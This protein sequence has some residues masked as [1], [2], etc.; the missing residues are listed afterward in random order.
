MSTDVPEPAALPSRGTATDDIVRRL[1]T[2]PS[3]IALRRRTGDG[4]ADVDVTE[5]ADQV[6]CV[7]KGLIASG[8]DQGARVALLASTRPA[9]TVLDYAIWWCGAVSVPMYDTVSTSAIA[10]VVADAEPIA[11]IAERADQLVD[12]DTAGMTI[13]LLDDSPGALHLLSELGR[14]VTD[15]QL[16]QRRS[17][18]DPTDVATIIYTSGTM[19][20]SKGCPLTHE[21]FAAEV[22]AAADHLPALFTPNASTLLFLPLAHIFAR[23]VQV[24]A[25]RTG[26]VLGHCATVQELEQQLG[27][28]APDFVLS[29]PRVFEQMFNRASAMAWA[30]GQGKAF[31]RAVRTAI[32]VSRAIDAGS[33]GVALRLRHRMYASVYE[34]VLGIFGPNITLAVCGGA[35]LGERLTHFYRGAGLPILEGYGLTETTAAIACNQPGHHRIGTVG[36]PL[37]GVEVELA[38]DGE[39][40]VRGPQVFNGYWHNESATA[41]ALAPDGWFSTGD[42]G[43]IDDDGYVRVIGRKKEIIVTA[44]GKSVAPA[45]LEDLVRAHP[46]VSHCLVVGDGRPFIGALI[47]VDRESWSGRPD[48]PELRTAISR[49]IEDANA[50]VSHAESIRRFVILDDDWT[51]E[52]GY[53]T[54]S[55][56]VRRN[57]VLRDF[58][59][60]VEALFTR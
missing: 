56:K 20:R 59:D 37:P 1:K 55:M 42:L 54:P 28:F 46:H 34:R 30:D 33:V 16:E 48:D 8:I 39:L 38:D 32:D 45:V 31:D 12:V 50:H 41:A 13:W 23:V 10:K 18:V 7:A 58:H 19:G 24:G 51:R 44:G 15:D 6:R 53:L 17:A 4:W 43:E 60:T 40:L 36:R 52:N 49:A 26:T 11:I 57:A 3:G 25:L 22:D 14:G 5:F 9:W 27:E 47:T 2:D 21:N 35:P 29:V